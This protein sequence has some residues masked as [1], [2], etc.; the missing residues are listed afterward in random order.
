MILAFRV[1]FWKGKCKK[2]LSTCRV[3]GQLYSSTLLNKTI[4]FNIFGILNKALLL[5]LFEQS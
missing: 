1:T 4:I 5:N 2:K 3:A